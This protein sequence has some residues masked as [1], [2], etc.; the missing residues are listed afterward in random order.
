MKKKYKVF[1]IVVFIIGVL[2]VS[3]A[4][5]F[6]FKKEEPKKLIDFKGMTLEEVLKYA[7]ENKITINKTFSNDDTILKNYVISQ[8]VLP[9]TKLTEGQVVDIVVSIG[10]DYAKYK[11]DEL[12]FVPI[13]M[14]H[15]IHDKKNSETEYTGGNIDYAGYQRTTEAFRNDLEFY[16]KEGYRMIRL[17]DYINGIVDVELGKSPIVLTFDDGLENNIKVTGLDS[18][19]NIIVRLE[20]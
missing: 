4:I 5:F 17:N 7:N 15:G 19:G 12:G 8:S 18:D 13:M 20:F 2:V 9:N 1:N 14:Y 3:F 6:I 11:V 10:P 16:Y